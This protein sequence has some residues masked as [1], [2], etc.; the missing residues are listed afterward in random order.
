MVLDC[1]C[2]SQRDASSTQQYTLIGRHHNTRRN[3]NNAVI[4]STC[5]AQPDVSKF[6]GASLTRTAYQSMRTLAA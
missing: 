3:K 6:H 5:K 4:L 1:G 2:L